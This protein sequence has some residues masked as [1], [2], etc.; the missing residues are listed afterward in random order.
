MLRLGFQDVQYR[1]T[2]TEALIYVR[3][4]AC[5]AGD[6]VHRDDIRGNREPCVHEA[7]DLPDVQLPLLPDHAQHLH[8][9]PCV[10]H[11]HRPHAHL[12]VSK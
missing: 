7:A 12:R 10:L 11:V 1:A 6:G 8:L 4:N 3:S 9:R 2:A 5:W